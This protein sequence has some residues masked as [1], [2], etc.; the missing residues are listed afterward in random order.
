[1]PSH[2][3]EADFPRVQYNSPF[4]RTLTRRLLLKTK[5]EHI[6]IQAEQYEATMPYILYLL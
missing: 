5:Y 3:A 6:A 1:M 2:F 4:L